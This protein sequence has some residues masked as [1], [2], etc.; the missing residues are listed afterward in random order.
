MTGIE[1]YPLI[2]VSWAASGSLWKFPLN[3]F[4]DYDDNWGRF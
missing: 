3:D 1:M 2:R 4:N